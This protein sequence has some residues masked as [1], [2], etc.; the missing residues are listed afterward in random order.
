LN[1]ESSTIPEQGA[2]TYV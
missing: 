1:T 2:V